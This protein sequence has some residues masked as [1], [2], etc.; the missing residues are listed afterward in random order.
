M[1][2]RKSNH[3][4]HS[5]I[6]PTTHTSDQSGTCPTRRW[7][8]YDG[9]VSTSLF[10]G[11][12]SSRFIPPN[13]FYDIHLSFRFLQLQYTFHYLQDSFQ[14]YFLLHII[15]L[16]IMVVSDPLYDLPRDLE[17]KLSF[18]L[19]HPLDVFCC[20]PR[21][22]RGKPQATAKNPSTQNGPTVPSSASPL[23]STMKRV[24]SAPC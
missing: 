12:S 20:T 17:G 23:S 24:L 13:L 11:Y 9:E 7:G 6:S 2:L 15:L 10:L 5:H 3:P 8:G 16:E 19:P 4:S 1:E 21:I 14:F 18:S 22:N